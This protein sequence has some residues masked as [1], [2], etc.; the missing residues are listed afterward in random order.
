MTIRLLVALGA[1][2]AVCG[3][4]L[5][6]GVVVPV[7]TSTAGYLASVNNIGTETLKFVDERRGPA[8]EAPK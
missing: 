7:I 8:C 6:V 1:A 4:G 3:C 5:P 2:L